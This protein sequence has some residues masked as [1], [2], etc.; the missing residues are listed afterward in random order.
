[1]NVKLK[2]CFLVF[3]LAAACAPRIF[4]ANL[5]I[6]VVETGEGRGEAVPERRGAAYESSSVWETCLLDVFFEA[7]H[8][9]SNAPALGGGEGA[10]IPGGD[11]LDF[12]P[13][14][15]A[16]LEEAR[17]GGADYIVLAL[18]SYPASADMRTRPDQ[19]RLRVYDLRPY[20]FTGQMTAFLAGAGTETEA[21]QAK[22]LIRGLIPYVND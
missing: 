1:M 3:L 19:V 14:L 4:A 12:P 18:L 17:S 16:E 21:E 11:S 5:L 8:I 2:C 7:G 10:G 22:R 9:V 13:E 6:L 20:R 15:E